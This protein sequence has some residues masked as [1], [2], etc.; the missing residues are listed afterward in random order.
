MRPVLPVL[1]CLGL[2]GPVMAES[3]EYEIPYL[4]PLAPFTITSMGPEGSIFAT[5]GTH[6][7]MCY[8]EYSDQA[9]HFENCVPV[10]S[11]FTAEGIDYIL[12]EVEQT[13]ETM[14]PFVVV[15]TVRMAMQKM[16]SCLVTSRNLD[17]F[18]VQLTR[19][20]NLPLGI[21]NYEDGRDAI[22]DLFEETAE[23]MV[24]N[25]DMIF[26]D[27]AEFAVLTECPE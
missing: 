7:F 9:A 3:H 11:E 21:L 19:E 20:M 14:P 13:L 24:E 6:T 4:D 2:A 17:P 12:S 23:V 8:L 16:D 15:A 18:V 27:D 1:A 26:N 25:G 5:D 10:V 22:G